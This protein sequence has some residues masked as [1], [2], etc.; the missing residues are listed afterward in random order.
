MTRWRS[1]ACV[2]ILMALAL[3]L[4]LGHVHRYKEIS[5]VDESQHLDY[6]IRAGQGH[7]V[8]LGDLL[9]QSTMRLET[10]R[11]LDAAF[12]VKIRPCV[13]DAA[14]Q[15]DPASF[16]EAGF[17]TAAIH[18]P[19]YYAIDG[20]VAR[21]ISAALPGEQDQ[22]TTGR[23][24][25]A[26]WLMAAVGALWSMLR[27]FGA[28][29]LV[30]SSLIAL[31]IS[32]P[33]VLF[34]SATITNDG[35][36]LF[37]GALLIW[38]VLRW[39]RGRL[40]AVIVVLAAALCAATKVT[41]LVVV[42]TVV[43]YLLMRCDRTRILGVFAGL[44]RRTRHGV[45][46]VASDLRRLVMSVAVPLTAVGVMLAWQLV[47]RSIATVAIS[48]I[49]MTQRYT[50]SSFP[51]GPFVDAWRQTF[52]PLFAPYLAPFLRTDAVHLTSG[53]TAVLLVVLTVTAMVRSA[54]GSRTRILSVA[55]LCSAL[56]AGPAIVAFNYV[57]QGVYVDI[58]FRYALVVVPAM[59]AV[60]GT[61]L[62]G[63]RARIL[64]AGYAV[65][66]VLSVTIAF[67]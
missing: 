40:P 24:A 31:T 14:E 37:C 42:L 17:N 48:E 45:G 54:P 58:P 11:R 23:V 3:G 12:D 9:G 33:T 35:T 65:A 66:G 8:G 19:T 15:L 32:A 55:A 64:T 43:L 22:L 52:D 50:V 7:L 57:F 62:G 46:I 26:L 38:A 36:A 59:V 5:P 25:G 1:A 29:R 6:L 53:L 4:V 49:P 51:V 63:P 21:I 34:A 39:E 18:P 44:R 56:L 41:N 27:E 30:A 20:A 67:R 10:C 2:L 16:Q 60:V 28:D 61:T 13:T 47:A